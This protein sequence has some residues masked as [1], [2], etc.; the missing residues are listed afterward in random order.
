MPKIALGPCQYFWPREQTETFYARIA[1]TS[2][3]IVY[4]GESVCPKRRELRPEDWI[5]LGRE[6]A[7]QG[8][9]VVLSTL[10]LLEA[11]SELGMVRRLCDNGEFRVEANDVA[12]VQMLREH[13]LPF[14]GGA[15]LNIYNPESLRLYREQGMFRWVMPLEMGR[16]SLG[17]LL[18]DYSAA[19]VETEVFAYGRMPLAWSARCYTARYHDLPKDQCGL[20][21]IE[22]PEG[23]PVHTRDGELF[24]NINGIQTQ[25]GR[26]TNLLPEWQNMADMGVD[27]LRISPRPEGTAERIE[28][29]AAEM[30]GEQGAVAAMS[31]GEVEDCNGYWFG[32]AGMQVVR[33]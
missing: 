32:Q 3:D 8:K 15:F 30:R 20:R 18:A 11:R 6:L 29:L 27:V 22:D 25:S 5:A 24:L 28:A 10:T 21:C 7:A 23:I 19:D 4:L 13:Q 1:E 2:A 16:D 17:A 9:E 12:A 14:V 33:E 31:E 26:V